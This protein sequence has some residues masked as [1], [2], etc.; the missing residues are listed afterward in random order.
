MM[1]KLVG[2]IAV[3][4]LVFLVA[5]QGVPYGRTHSNPPVRREPPWESPE[6][7]A[8]AVRACFDC[9]S[10]QTTWPWY[11]NVA[12][13]SWLVERD[14]EKGRRHLNFSEW[15]RPQK[16]A[17]E[18]AKSVQKGAMPPWYYP[19]AQLSAAERLAL[20]QGLAAT[21]GQSDDNKDKSSE[22]RR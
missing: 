14:V 1:K 5:I 22:S 17:S 20:V 2:V 19:W 15:D 3:G 13:A 4:I 11:S 7:R 16:E 9:H 6:T 10:N 21:L 18:S 8:L 12:P